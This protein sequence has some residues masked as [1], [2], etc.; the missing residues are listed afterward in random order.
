MRNHR[1]F[2]FNYLF[3]IDIIF[4]IFQI[5]YNVLRTHNICT[6]YIYNYLLLRQNFEI[7]IYNVISNKL[8]IYQ[9]K[10]RN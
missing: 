1:I 5:F 6:I 2:N 4:E 10:I 7:F 3:F 9:I 8:F